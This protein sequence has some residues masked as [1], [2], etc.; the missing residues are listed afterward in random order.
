[1]SV[2]NDNWISKSKKI[3][4]NY[5]LLD[6]TKYSEIFIRLLAGRG[7]FDIKKIKS[8]LNPSLK[9]MH[10][11]E[12]LPN[13]EKATERII[14]SIKENERILIFGDYDTDGIISTAILYN[15]FFRLGINTD[16][17]IPDRFL[18]GY[19]IN[20]EFFERNKIE[21]K[22]D[23]IIC[24]DCGTNAKDVHNQ[25][26]A[27]KLDIDIIVCDH[28]ES[29]EKDPIQVSVSKLQE[30][31]KNKNNCL[32]INPKLEG[33]D[34]PF[35][36]LSGAGVTFKFIWGILKNIKQSVIKPKEYLKEI[37]DL[38]AISTVADIVPLVDE[39]RVI[40]KKGLEI[41][42]NTKNRGLKKLIDNSIENIK[43]INS[44]HIG[45]LI[46]PR[47]NAPG[48][49]NNAKD[50]LEILLEKNIDDI[51]IDS[52][53]SNLDKFNIERK[54]IQ[55]TIISHIEDRYN[56]AEIAKD[57][58]IFIARSDNWNEG[59][60]GI[61]ASDIVK[62]FNI[63]VI[64]FNEKDE[65]L[66][67]SGR[68]PENF[69]LF[70]NLKKLSKYFIKFGG[71]SQACG[72]TMPVCNYEDFKKDLLE[73]AK[74]EIEIKD[75]IKNFYYDLELSFK[76]ISVELAKEISLMEPFGEGNKKPLFITRGCII[77]NDVFYS[78]NEKHI[79]FKVKNSNRVLDS[80]IFNFR[81]ISECEAKLFRGNK[82]DMLYNIDLSD[83]SYND[84]QQ[85]K[86]I[87]RDIHQSFVI[88]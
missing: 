88:Q 47:L 58:R 13:I 87:T 19:D 54:K 9:E 50:S 33:S 28:H 70:Y 18:D 5:N 25:I 60:V 55:Q 32:I 77:Y 66:K 11:P 45:F 46:S 37:L 75:I 76:D 56:I 10:Q 62:R 61:V 57:Q 43:R 83:D 30:S 16:Y 64:L 36:H 34:Y 78:K 86:L 29:S 21:D 71:H 38:V 40:V 42:K 82:I 7:I 48:R 68:S 80:V 63:P 31:A 41:I 35:K 59:V 23:L 51:K 24:V 73:V 4:D 3:I 6:N 69:N 85:I 20:I 79:F 49:M 39:N 2:C 84:Y 17:H 81:Y 53:A 44:Y 15:F 74:S 52:M 8:F 72:I 14:R 67:G 1:M 27:G 12:F 22:Y 65:I 26:I